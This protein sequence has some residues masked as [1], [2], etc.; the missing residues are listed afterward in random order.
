MVGGDEN[1]IEKL[2]FCLTIILRVYD[3]LVLK[4]LERTVKHNLIFTF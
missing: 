3:F 4:K 2:D 1:E